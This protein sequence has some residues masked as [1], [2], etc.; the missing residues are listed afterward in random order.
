MSD[1]GVA[2]NEAEITSNKFKRNKSTSFNEET[3][4]AHSK[5]TKVVDA[6]KA[7]KTSLKTNQTKF[8]TFLSKLKY[9]KLITKLFLTS[10]PADKSVERVS[11]KKSLTAMNSNEFSVND[12][13]K[14]R[15]ILATHM[16]RRMK[17]RIYRLKLR[18]HRSQMLEKKQKRLRQYELKKKL[19][20]V[21]LL[22]YLID[23]NSSKNLKR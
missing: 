8:K 17:Q 19:N 4:D 12:Y 3:Q 21:K 9:K 14:A 20:Q 10:L 6:L 23:N 18:K 11:S 2:I 13:K 22:Q 7:P 1:H 15:K 16:N 5:A